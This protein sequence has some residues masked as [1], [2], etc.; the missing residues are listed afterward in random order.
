MSFN[1]IQPQ[2]IQLPTFSSESGNLSFTDNSTGVTVELNNTIDGGP[3]NF[4]SGVKS[5][6]IDVVV[7]GPDTDIT[8]GIGNIA[9]ANSGDSIVSGNHNVVLGGSPN[10]VSGDL[11]AVINNNGLDQGNFSKSNTVIGGGSVVIDDSITGSVGLFSSTFARTMGQN[12]T[13]Y[14]GGQSGVQIVAPT[15]FTSNSIYNQPARFNS[16]SEFHGVNTYATNSSFTNSGTSNFVG[17]TTFN[18]G[19]TIATNAATFTATATFNNS[20]EFNSNVLL[21]DNSLA[22][23]RNFI[24]G[25][26]SDHF[27]E[28]AVGGGTNQAIA[29]GNTGAVTILVSGFRFK[30]SGQWLAD[31]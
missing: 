8:G 15:T 29:V 3:I 12:E 10:L 2:Q 31:S 24:T 28:Q 9:L 5:K 20:A 1:K 11:N 16:S 21:I 14:I 13:V 25:G 26:G 4:A 23:S 19:V 30:V 18:G 17:A 7:V 22:A 6:G 27:I